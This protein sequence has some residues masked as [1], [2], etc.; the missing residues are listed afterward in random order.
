MS[1]KREKTWVYLDM[2]WKFCRFYIHEQ[3]RIAKAS[4]KIE[5][6]DAHWLT[7]T[8]SHGYFLMGAVIVYAGVHVCSSASL[9]GFGVRLLDL[10][11]VQET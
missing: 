3:F 2:W 1:Q 7:R 10:R 9:K 5:N 8:A 6:I 11:W 4:I